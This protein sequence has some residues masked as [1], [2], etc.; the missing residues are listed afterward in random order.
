MKCVQDFTA[1]GLGDMP[2]PHINWIPKTKRCVGSPQL[3]KQRDIMVFPSKVFL[4]PRN[5]FSSGTKVVSGGLVLSLA[6]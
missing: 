5:I 4:R 1:C 3:T 2:G 6:L